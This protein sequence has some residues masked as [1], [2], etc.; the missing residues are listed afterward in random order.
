MEYLS[1]FGKIVRKE[2]IYCKHTEGLFR[3]KNNGDRKYLVDFSDGRDMGSYHVLDGA[4]VT[5]SYLG[6]RNT[7]GRCHGTA[8]TCPGGGIAQLCE[9]REGPKVNLNEHMRVLWGELNYKPSN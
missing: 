7:C 4:H 3:G 1:F 5:V 6:Q 2:V 9:E 8:S